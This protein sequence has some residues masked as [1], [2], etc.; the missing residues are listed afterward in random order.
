MTALHHASHPSAGEPQ[1]FLKRT[2]QNRQTQEALPLASTPPPDPGR[3]KGR[4]SPRT[5]AAWSCS[6]CY[7]WPDRLSDRPSPMGSLTHGAAAGPPR[8][9]RYVMNRKKWALLSALLLATVAPLP[10]LTPPQ[11]IPAVSAKQHI[12]SGPSRDTDGDPDAFGEGKP[13]GRPGPETTQLRDI[14]DSTVAVGHL[15]DHQFYI[16]LLLSFILRIR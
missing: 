11:L 4:P 9:A 1:F 7:L 10:T 14:P 12:E 6:D 3:C 2:S 16:R 5:H 8:R 15:I 13:V